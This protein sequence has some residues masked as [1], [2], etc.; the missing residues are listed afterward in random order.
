MLVIIEAAG[1]LQ[2]PTATC[3]GS[4]A[5]HLGTV[6][7]MLPIYEPCSKLLTYSLVAFKGSLYKPYAIPS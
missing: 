3:I 6:V 1:P 7:F 4:R 2:H 5:L